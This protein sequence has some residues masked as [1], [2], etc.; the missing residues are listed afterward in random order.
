MA[1]NI[2]EI[3]FGSGRIATGSMLYQYDYGQRIIF[4]DLDLPE[5]YEVH[6]A[7]DGDAQTVNM[8]GDADGVPIPDQLLQSPGNLK[9]YIYL[10]EGEEDGETEYKA[11]IP[12]IGRPE[13]SDLEPIPV[14]QDAITQA[15]AAL[16]TAVTE[17]SQSAADA[18]DSADAA[19]QSAQQA[20]ESAESIDTS[21][22]ATKSYVDSGMQGMSNAISGLGQS[23]GA[24]GADVAKKYADTVHLSEQT[25]TETQKDRVLTQIGAKSIVATEKTRAEGAETALGTRITDEVSRAQ[26][27]ESRILGLANEAVKYTS[28]QYLTGAQKAQARTNIGAITASEAPV[29][30]V[31]GQTGAVTIPTATTSANGLMSSQDKSRLDDLYADYSSALSALGV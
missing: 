7:G 29:Q 18:S 1:M 13:P 20:K 27:E 30:S 14:Q 11:L 22:F 10:H 12:V 23:I 4:P 17:S 3:R 24:L 25:L 8:I 9:V 6:F 19:A 16:N 15:I 5:A 21:S 26:S 2:T 28:L 31:N